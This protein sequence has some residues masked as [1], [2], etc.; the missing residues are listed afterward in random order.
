MLDAFV[1]LSAKTVRLNNIFVNH[2]VCPKLC[3]CA[4]VLNV[5][6]VSRDNVITTQVCYV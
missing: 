1:E 2:E 5:T 6:S 4:L 3:Q